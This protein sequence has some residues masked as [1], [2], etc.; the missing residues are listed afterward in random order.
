MIRAAMISALIVCLSFAGTLSAHT[1]GIDPAELR[2]LGNSRYVLTS[3]VPPALHAAIQTPILPAECEFEG[4]PS[5]IR[6]SYAVRFEFRCSSPLIAGQVIELP[7]QR[8]GVMLT[9]A[10]EAREPV[11]LLSTRSGASIRINLVD[12]Q[13]GS[14][15]L[16]AAAK[17]YTLLGLDH[18]LA[19]IDHLLFVLALLFLVPKD[20][21]L[22][23]AVTAFTAA[24]SITLALATLGFVSVSAAPVEAAIALSIVFLCAEI[25]RGDRDSIAFRDTWVVA[26]CFGLLHGFGF[27]GALAEIGLPAGEIPVAL[28]F[29][30]VGV[31]LGQLLFIAVA[32]LV[33]KTVVATLPRAGNSPFM[34]ASRT[35]SVYVVG[36]VSSYWFIERALPI[37]LVNA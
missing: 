23:R 29:F 18:I 19:G 13:A 25:M 11:T 26:F 36:I 35:A 24:H 20:W 33:L 32:L 15:G 4:D 31:E 16:S 21:A 12:Y 27:A 6:G 28:L 2:D 37:F 8:D 22:V 14:G 7:W 34:L 9:V 10:W 30:N 3:R 1:L 17:R 5:G